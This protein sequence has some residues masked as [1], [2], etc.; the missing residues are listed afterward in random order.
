METRGMNTSINNIHQNVIIVCHF[1]VIIVCHFEVIIVC[2]FEA[3]LSNITLQAQE[4]IV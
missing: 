2:H 4:F 3:C 1:E